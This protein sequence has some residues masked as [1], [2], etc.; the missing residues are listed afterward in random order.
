MCS[1]LNLK[2]D[3]I[4]NVLTVVESLLALSFMASDK[5]ILTHLCCFSVLMNAVLLTFI[6]LCNMEQSHVVAIL[7]QT[8]C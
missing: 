8:S 3:C 6:L 5:L 7:I 1:K 4:Y 2:A